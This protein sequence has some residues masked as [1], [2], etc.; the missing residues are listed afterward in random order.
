[1]Q[2]F[3]LYGDDPVVLVTVGC[4]ILVLLQRMEAC[5]DPFVVVVPQQHGNFLWRNCNRALRIHVINDLVTV[6]FAFDKSRKLPPVS[7]AKYIFQQTRRQVIFQF[8]LELLLQVAQQAGSVPGFRSVA[9][10]RGL[11][12]LFLRPVSEAK[13]R[14]RE[15]FLE[16]L[17][18]SQD[19]KV[20]LFHVHRRR[21]RE[22][23]IAQKNRSRDLSVHC[24]HQEKRPAP[25]GKHTR[26]TLQREIAHM[27]NLAPQLDIAQLEVGRFVVGQGARRGRRK[28]WL[29][30]TALERLGGNQSRTA[31]N[32]QSSN[33]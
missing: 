2:F 29:R 21:E 27:N 17:T 14:V 23:A 25:K 30:R 16:R 26:L 33:V 22:T 9:G 10:S 3:V 6:L 18:L 20:S 32:N 24:L 4:P 28:G 15:L 11:A 19:G 5:P 1:F 8:L 7:R 31:E 12:D 13:H